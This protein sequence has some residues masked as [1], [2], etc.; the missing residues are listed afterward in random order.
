MN[1]FELY[2]GKTVMHHG[3]CTRK[4]SAVKIGEF[5]SRERA[6]ARAERDGKHLCGRCPK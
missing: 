2:E 3:D 5:N 6:T 1:A 4:G